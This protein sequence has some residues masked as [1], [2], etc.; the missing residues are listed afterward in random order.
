VR[1]VVV[2]G[3]VVWVLLSRFLEAASL[4]R[5]SPREAGAGRGVFRCAFV[6]CSL[7]FWA[8]CGASSSIFEV[9]GVLEVL[10]V[11]R[12]VIAK[13]KDVLRKR[14]SVVTLV[15]KFDSFCI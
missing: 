13:N 7:L 4:I 10:E 1:R 14:Y 15:E 5:D 3:A 2:G 12:M 11:V 8:L 6:A 9:L